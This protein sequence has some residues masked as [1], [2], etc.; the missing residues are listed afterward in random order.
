MPQTSF[1]LAFHMLTKIVVASMHHCDLRNYN[2]TQGCVGLPRGVLWRF[3]FIRWRL[4]KWVVRV[5]YHGMD[6]KCHAFNYRLS[7][8]SM[9]WCALSKG[10]GC[11]DIVQNIMPAEWDRAT[12]MIRASSTL[13]FS[14]SIH[15]HCN[16]NLRLWKEH[17]QEKK[18]RENN[19]N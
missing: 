19:L 14:A 16:W 11:R 3:I 10:N 15:V 18:R 8:F 5:W 13:A 9:C 2:F 6:W 1:P 7:A 12:I 17:F 4:E